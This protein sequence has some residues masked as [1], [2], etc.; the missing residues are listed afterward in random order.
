MIYRLEAVCEYI[1]SK[2]CEIFD[3]PYVKYCTMILKG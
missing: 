1:A 2:V 3:V